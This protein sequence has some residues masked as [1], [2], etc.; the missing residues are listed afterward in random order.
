[1]TYDDLNKYP[2]EVILLCLQLTAIEV[3]QRMAWDDMELWGLL[4]TEEREKVLKKISEMTGEEEHK[5]AYANSV[6]WTAIAYRKYDS[7]KTAEKKIR[8][9]RELSEKC[10]VADS[11]QMQAIEAVYPGMTAQR[12]TPRKDKEKP[13]LVTQLLTG[14]TTA[15]VCSNSAG[16]MKDMRQKGYEAFGEE[17]IEGQVAMAKRQIGECKKVKAKIERS[18]TDTHGLQVEEL[19][20]EAEVLLAG[21]EGTDTPPMV[22]KGMLDEMLKTIEDEREGREG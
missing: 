18:K 3:L 5:K 19:I 12:W 6:Y 9:A 10:F 17:D 11:P 16:T 4:L 1:M 13:K 21:I 15:I 2:K 22:T 14:I 20:Y 8:E 7:E